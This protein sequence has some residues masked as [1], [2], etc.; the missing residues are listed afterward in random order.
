MSENKFYP[1]YGDILDECFPRTIFSISPQYATPLAQT[2]CEFD[3]IDFAITYVIEALNIDSPIFFIEIKPP[4]HLPILLARKDAEDQVRRRFGE[5][6]QSWWT[7]R[8]WRDGV[9]IL[10]SQR[11]LINSWELL[12]RLSEWVLPC[13]VYSFIIGLPS[14]GNTQIC[15]LCRCM[16]RMQSN[17]LFFLLVELVVITSE[18]ILGCQRVSIHPS[19]VL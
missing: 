3:A 18:R 10:W 8:L 16:R 15:L 13:R 6:S 4:I 17:S 11:G 2:V 5:I 12:R 9:Q 7:R 19:E 14:N 1:L